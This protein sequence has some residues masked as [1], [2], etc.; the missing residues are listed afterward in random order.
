MVAVIPDQ[1]RQI[2][3]AA[4][5]DRPAA[6]VEPEDQ[7][8]PLKGA[9]HDGEPAIGKHVR[10]GFV[11]AAGAIEI[12]DAIGIEHAEA[13]GRARRDVDMPRRRGG[14]G[15]EDA[16]APNKIAMLLLEGG[17]ALGHGERS[18][19]VDPRTLSAAA[20]LARPVKAGTARGVNAPGSAQLAG[21]HGP[22]HCAW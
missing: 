7:R 4:A 8:R 1:Q 13:I 17:K 5:P 2:L 9:K 21:L 19:I 10:C 15:E 6:A 11:A 14:S 3:V 16:L 20:A 12:D 22:Q 18:E